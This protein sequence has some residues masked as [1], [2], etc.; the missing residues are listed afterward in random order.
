MGSVPKL[1]REFLTINQTSFVEL[2]CLIIDAIDFDA[3]RA[4]E[5]IV[6]ASGVSSKIDSMRKLFEGLDATLDK[7]SVDMEAIAQV[8]VFAVYW[9]QLGFLSSIEISYFEGETEAEPQLEGWV[10]KF[11]TDKQRYYKNCITNA[12]DK[13][14]GDVFSLINGK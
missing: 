11:Q 8:P 13:S 3:S 4:S 9:P 12:L 5:K 7:A 6:V 14:P 10:L 1:I 2:G